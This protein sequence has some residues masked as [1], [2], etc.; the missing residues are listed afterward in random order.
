[1]VFNGAIRRKEEAMSAELQ[2]DYCDQADLGDIK[3]RSP[4]AS[5]RREKHLMHTNQY[6]IREVAKVVGMSPTFVRKVVGRRAQ[7]G[8]SEVLDLLD[9]DAYR[10]TFIPRSRVIDYLNSQ[11]ASAADI[12]VIPNPTDYEFRLGHVLD[13]ARSVPEKSVQCVV[14]STPYWAMRVYE[15]SYTAV[16]A[17]GE[18]S[19][20]GHEQ[21]PEGFVRHTVEVLDALSRLLTDEGSIWLNVMDS[22]NTRT[23]VRRSAVEALRAMQGEDNRTWSEHPVRRYSAGHSYLKDGEQC[24]VPAMIAERASRIGLYVKTVITWAKVSSLPEPQDSR[25]SRNLEYVLHLTKQR[26]P[27][28]SRLAYHQSAPE[29]GGRN[30]ESESRKL[31]DVWILNTSS[32]GDGHG[33][34]FPTSLPGRCIGLTTAPRDL[35]LDPFVGS[36]NSGVAALQHGCAFLGWDVSQTY[37]SVAKERVGNTSCRLPFPV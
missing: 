8:V 7:L 36:G 10:E 20:Y 5:L 18:V 34:Q 22:F 4:I 29:F 32:G 37:L 27:K 17:D 26:T 28:F 25:V 2:Q 21:T 31:S 15:D 13:L 23:Q 19:A 9:Q 6:C 24:L 1:M 11:Q 14:T 16:W 33:A 12:N 30:E 3:P 35:V